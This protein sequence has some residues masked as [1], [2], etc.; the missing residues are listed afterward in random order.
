VPACL[1]WSL[2]VAF[3]W[4]EVPIGL[5]A[6]FLAFQSVNLPASETEIWMG[7]FA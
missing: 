6:T 1:R 2:A 3:P 5:I 4:L 7:Q